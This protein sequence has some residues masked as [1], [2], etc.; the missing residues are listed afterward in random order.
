MS[1]IGWHRLLLILRIIEILK[2]II[3][4]LD[5]KV[6][7]AGGGYLKTNATGV[8]VP[9]VARAAIPV[10]GFLLRDNVLRVSIYG[11]PV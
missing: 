8:L 6:F 7:R 5:P 3:R 2:L 1:R 10:G 9:V 11:Y 4:P